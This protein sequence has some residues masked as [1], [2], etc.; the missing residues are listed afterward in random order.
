MIPPASNDLEKKS[1]SWLERA[2]VAVLI[3]VLV[4][5]AWMV[6]V[7]YQ[8]TWLRVVSE[9]IEV[10]VVLGLFV[11]AILLVSLVALLHTRA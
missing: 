6:T 1:A 5:L 8:P 4:A 2:T 3:L 11:A 7:A 9:E 10:G